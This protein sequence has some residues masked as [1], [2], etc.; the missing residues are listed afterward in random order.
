MPPWAKSGGSVN[1]TS[2]VWLAG[3]ALSVLRRSDQRS[4]GFCSGISM[5]ART[6]TSGGWPGRGRHRLGAPHRR[7]DK[8]LALRDRSGPLRRARPSAPP[9]CRLRRSDWRTPPMRSAI[10]GWAPL[11]RVSAGRGWPGALANK[12]RMVVGR[13]QMRNPTTA[14]TI[15]PATDQV[16]IL[17]RGSAAK[18]DFFFSGG[19]S[20]QRSTRLSSRFSG[21]GSARFSGRLSARFSR[22][23]SGCGTRGGAG[24]RT[25][26]C[27]TIEDG[28]RVGG[29]DF[30]SKSFRSGSGGDG[31]IGSP[32]ASRKGGGGGGSRR[33]EDGRGDTGSRERR[34]SRASRARTGSGAGG[35]A[36][37]R[38]ASRGGGR[39][40][41]RGGS[42]STR[43]SAG[44]DSA[45][46]GG[47]GATATPEAAR[48]LPA[49][50]VTPPSVS[51]S[52]TSRK[53]FR[54]R[55]DSDG[56]VPGDQRGRSGRAGT[57]RGGSMPISAC[58]SAACTGSEA[59]AA[60]AGD[61]PYLGRSRP[62]LHRF[63]RRLRRLRHVLVHP[64]SRRRRR[65][66]GARRRVGARAA[67]RF[68][69]HLAD[70]LLERQPLAGNV[71]FAERR[72][73]PA[74]LRDQ[75]RARPVV[76]GPT[77]LAGALVEPGHGLGDERVII[78]HRVPAPLCGPHPLVV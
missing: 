71:G 75:C 41:G 15:S 34:G 37:P 4:G 62:H 69:L 33:R 25:S 24:R 38:S 64:T 1:M 68:R 42:A 52:T 66:H 31:P 18:R 17:R 73:H 40:A 78:G 22:R 60:A 67:R 74:Q 72:R 49:G 11:T 63:D 23:F 58:S 19:F 5:S 35:R 10:L 70:R 3:S 76:Q 48:P 43:G 32:G 59:T 8:A 61:T 27:R 7:A 47:D 29:S 77:R 57:S 6:A 16:A 36:N 2:M 30:T 28:G 44:A 13:F 55:S 46:A 14:M 53:P 45:A 20:A 12:P 54:P 50:A 51:P 56:P 21:R 39:R 9:W 26:S 65:R